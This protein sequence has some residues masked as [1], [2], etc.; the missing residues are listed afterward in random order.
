MIAIL[1]QDLATEP[2]P[3]DTMVPDQVV[4][5][6]HYFNKID[7]LALRSCSR[8]LPHELFAV[9]KEAGSVILSGRRLA[10]GNLLKERANLVAT[11]TDPRPRAHEMRDERTFDRC[12]ARI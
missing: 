11:S 7:L 3:I 12:V 5:D 6:L 1:L 2:A 8:I 10:P 9:S 4:P